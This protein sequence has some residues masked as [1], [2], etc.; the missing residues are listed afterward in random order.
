MLGDATMAPGSASATNWPA[1]PMLA[2]IRASAVV[3]SVSIHWVRIVLN[4]AWIAGKRD[5]R[6]KM[7]MTDFMVIPGWPR[8]ADNEV[9]FKREG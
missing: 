6:R 9:K 3:F 8:A 1:G 4:C 5:G 2:K 7:R